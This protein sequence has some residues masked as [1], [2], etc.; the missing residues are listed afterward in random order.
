MNNSCEQNATANRQFDLG[1][2]PVRRPAEKERVAGELEKTRKLMVETLHDLG[3]GPAQTAGLYQIETGGSMLRA[4]LAIA[5]GMAFER[6]ARY[7][8]VCAAACEFIHN[9]SLIHDDLMDRDEWR[10]GSLSV[11]KRFGEDLAVCTGDLLVC[12]AFAVAS[13]LDNPQEARELTRLIANRSSRII[14]GQSIEVGGCAEHCAPGFRDYLKATKAK[15]APLIEMSLL[16]GII[17]NESEGAL[18]EK[19][20]ELASAVGLAYQIIDDLDDLRNPDAK[21]SR[22]HPFHAGHFH[23]RGTG[24]DPAPLIRRATWHAESAMKRARRILGELDGCAPQALAPLVSPLLKRLEQRN[25]NHRP[26]ALRTGV[27]A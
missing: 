10:R 11:W 22:F 4:R 17:S 6:S 16:T 21:A 5:S 15:T 25:S 26:S 23:R 8:R 19:V 1:A 12:A 18:A 14:I 9:A 27:V 3:A 2:R 13:E 7:R 24:Q 20:G